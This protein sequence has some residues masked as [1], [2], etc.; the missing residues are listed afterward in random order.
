MLSISALD[1]NRDQLQALAALP[2]PLHGE[3]ATGI[4][5]MVAGWTT[6]TVWTFRRRENLLILQGIE[7]KLLLIVVHCSGLV[8]PLTQLSRLHISCDSWSLIIIICP[9]NIDFLRAEQKLKYLL[10]SITRFEKD[11]LSEGFVV[12]VRLSLSEGSS[13]MKCGAMVE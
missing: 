5:Q 11:N 2:T 8:T 10:C 9:K 1:V 4:H 7:R 6:V 3:S 13:Q 12:L